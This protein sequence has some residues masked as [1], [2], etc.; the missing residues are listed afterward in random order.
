VPLPHISL[1]MAAIA[2]TTKEG[3]RMRIVFA[4]ALLLPPM[5]TGCTG[6]NFLHHQPDYA[7]TGPTS[8]IRWHDDICYACE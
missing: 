3:S 6:R 5:L 1:Q 2:G 4:M 7:I 8:S